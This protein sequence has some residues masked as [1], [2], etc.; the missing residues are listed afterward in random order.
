MAL[1][2][3]QPLRLESVKIGLDRGS[4]PEVTKYFCHFFIL[5]CLEAMSELRGFRSRWSCLIG[6]KQDER[7]EV[8]EAL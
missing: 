1:R 4:D 3:E 8:Q 7:A 6:L 2:L 5:L